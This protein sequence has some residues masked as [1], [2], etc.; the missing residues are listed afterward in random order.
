MLSSRHSGSAV[1]SIRF[2]SMHT[3]LVKAMRSVKCV[4]EESGAVL[5]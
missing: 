3:G 1:S 5:F 4:P 2:S